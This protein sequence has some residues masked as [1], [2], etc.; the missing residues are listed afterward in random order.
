MIQKQRVFDGGLL[1]QEPHLNPHLDTLPTKGTEMG[2][3]NKPG[4]Q[5]YD[6]QPENRTAELPD[7][8]QPTEKKSKLHGWSPEP[9]PVLDSNLQQGRSPQSLLTTGRNPTVGLEVIFNP[10]WGITVRI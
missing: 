3:K 4:G 5:C 8:R 6:I 9:T 7:P 10:L 1:Q 2:S